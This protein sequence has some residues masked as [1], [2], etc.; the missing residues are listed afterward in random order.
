MQRDS[1]CA[2]RAAHLALVG[3]PCVGGANYNEKFTWGHE[4]TLKAMSTSTKTG[5]QNPGLFLHAACALGVVR[6]GYA[7]QPS[8]CTRCGMVPSLLPFVWLIAS[9]CSA[10]HNALTCA[11]GLE[12]QPGKLL[13][14]ETWAKHNGQHKAADCSGNAATISLSCYWQ[15]RHCQKSLLSN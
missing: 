3:Q 14:G 6:P 4:R 15:G 7:S 11:W 13:E 9:V 2:H 12:H 8:S 10:L 5:A 1:P